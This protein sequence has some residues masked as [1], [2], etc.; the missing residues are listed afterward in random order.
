VGYYLSEGN[1]VK[2]INSYQIKITQSGKLDIIYNDLKDLPV[3]VCKG[4]QALYING[5]LAEY[6]YGMGY[7]YQ[8]R[9]PDII[10]NFSKEDILAF[11]MAYALGDGSIRTGRSYKGYGTKPEITIFSS[12][13]GMIDDMT[14]L[15]LK[16]GFKPSF[17]VAKTKGKAV[18]HRNG[19]YVTNHD[20]YYIRLNR[21]VTAQT[22]TITQERI[23]YDSMVYCVELEKYHTLLVRRNGKILWSGNCRC[24]YT[25]LLSATGISDR[26][27]IAKDE[28]GN[29]IY[30]KARTYR[31]YAKEN[32]LPDLD[33]RLVKE[34]PA[35]YLRPG[36]SV[37]S[38][39]HQVVRRIVKN[40]EINIPRPMWER[41]G[42]P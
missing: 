38:I 18:K 17:Y 9:I 35:R 32:G 14:E 37:E 33:E 16:A 2:R 10:K 6:T 5:A 22:G 27:R 13:I 7:S 26:E 34:N 1:T 19:N 8:K 41:L 28:K 39:N 25:P 4:K 36:E 40:Q 31:E 3:N 12:S 21:N 23:A 30:T 29:R 42:N 24:R 15:A 11:L 20:M